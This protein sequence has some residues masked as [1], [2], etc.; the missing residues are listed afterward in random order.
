MDKNYYKI[1][2][3]EKT[4]TDDEIK[5]AYRKLALKYHPDKNKSPEAE[6][7]F[8]EIAEAYEVLS[9]KKKRQLF[10]QYGADG[11]KDGMPGSGAEHFTTQRDP[12]ATFAQ[13]FG[14]ANPFGIFFGGDDPTHV[15]ETQTMSMTGGLGDDYFAFGGP[16]G[17]V[18]AEPSRKRQPQDPP[19]ERN[20]YVSLEEVYLGCEKKMKISRMN[21]ANGVQ[22]K[23]EKVLKICVKPG[24]KAGTKITFSEEGDR[25]PGKIPADIV[26]IIRD[27]PHPL[28]RRE[29]SNLRY[30]ASITL[31][32]A[33]CGT[34]IKVP[35]LRN[36]FVTLKI[37]NEVIKNDTVK[38]IPGKGLPLP[39]D[40]K[41]H[42]D[43]LVSFNIC[44]PDKIPQS[45]KDILM[46]VLP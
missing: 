28:F 8:K 39:K 17:V 31:K 2:G 18:N 44:F 19:I 41:Q 7:R 29:E 30:R 43:L 34:E 20:L 11:L 21:V 40:N 27:K 6:G 33:L 38:C 10:D 32:Q 45:T 1:L 12:R 42:G 23:E 36:D 13:F 14:N 9:D 22:F 26:F 25:T 37:Y 5:K 4:A 24:W 16:F 15:F 35:T 46:D 3:I